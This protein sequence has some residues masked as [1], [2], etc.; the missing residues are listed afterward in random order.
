[1]SGNCAFFTHKNEK[2][3]SKGDEVTEHKVV[4]GFVIFTLQQILLE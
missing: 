1:M 3:G 4:R 2:V